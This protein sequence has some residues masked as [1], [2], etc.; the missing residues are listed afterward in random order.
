MNQSCDTHMNQSCDIHTNQS[1]TATHRN[2][3]Y[4]LI[5]R[6][7]S[8]ELHICV[9]TEIVLSDSCSHISRHKSHICVC[10]TSHICSSHA[11]RT[12]MF[13][14]RSSPET[15]DIILLSYCDLDT[16]WRRLIGSLI[17]IGHFW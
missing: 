9:C 5:T 13:P 17:F 8:A 7:R 12:A 10:D 2:A 15:L 14:T 11:T 4:K 6:N 3:P 16:G 1:C